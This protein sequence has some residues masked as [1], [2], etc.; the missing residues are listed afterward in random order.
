VRVL[1]PVVQP[2]MLPMLH[3]GQQVLLGSRVAGQL[4]GDHDTRR[5]HLLLQQLAQQTFSS[6]LIA[7]ALNQDVE[8]KPVLIH[9][10]PKPVLHPGNFHRDLVEVPF[11]ASPRQPA[12]DLVGEGL[13]ELETPLP[14]SLMA[15]RDATGG[16]DLIDVAQAEWK[17]KIEPDGM[18]D[19]LGRKAI[20]GVARADYVLV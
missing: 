4:V 10:P 15:D 11:I 2:F 18:V 6:R 19:D 8:H 16:E 20:A 5:T 9:C 7:P 14:Y 13:A 12:T 3:P 1:R 17:A